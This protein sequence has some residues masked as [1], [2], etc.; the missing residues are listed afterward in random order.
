MD[1]RDN[2][3]ISQMNEQMLQQ[4]EKIIERTK[5]ENSALKKI[6]EGLEKMEAEN[7]KNKKIRK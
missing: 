1:N 2:K 4:L 5:S 7:P 3:Y 6:L